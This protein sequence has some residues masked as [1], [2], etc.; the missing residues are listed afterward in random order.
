MTKTA[1]S[2]LA[3]RTARLVIDEMAQRM[4]QEGRHCRPEVLLAAMHKTLQAAQITE[5][6]E[7]LLES[8]DLYVVAAEIA[9]RA[10]AHFDRQ[11]APITLSR[12][13]K[14]RKNVGRRCRGHQG[15]T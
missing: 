1:T 15:R 7:G 9:V 5:R 2:A 13:R 6:D 10:N 3:R 8:I 11:H 4:A 14:A 12:W